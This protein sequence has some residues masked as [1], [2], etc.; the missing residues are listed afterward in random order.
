MRSSC[1]VTCPLRASGPP[2]TGVR[3]CTVVEGWIL[4]VEC[5]VRTTCIVFYF[6]NCHFFGV[7][8]GS[9]LKVIFV[10]ICVS[11]QNMIDSIEIA[12]NHWNLVELVAFYY[13]HKLVGLIKLILMLHKQ[14]LNLYPIFQN[15]LQIEHFY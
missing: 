3:M 5:S 12:L 14:W 13:Q 9:W 8:L 4:N 15:K 11:I 1:S 2:L 7:T 6:P 10:S